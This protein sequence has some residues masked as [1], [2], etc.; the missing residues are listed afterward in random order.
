MRRAKVASAPMKITILS[1]LSTLTLALVAAACGGGTPAPASA[2][3]SPAAGEAAASPAPEAAPPSAPAT[4]HEAA[5]G[6]QRGAFM[7]AHVVPRMREV[8]QAK[9]PTHFAQFGCKTCHG[10]PFHAKPSDALPKLTLK[11][12]ELT[13]FEEHPEVAKFMAEKVA[14]EMAAILGEKPFDPATKQGFGCAGCH[15]IEMK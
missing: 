4:W 9:D 15:G 5:T 7:K 11:N 3:S 6:Q 8:F 14:P 2:P 13:A 10:D 12:G 1:S